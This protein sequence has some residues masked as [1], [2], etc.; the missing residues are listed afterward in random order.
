MS[1]YTTPLQFG[2][3]LG[4]AMALR[5]WFRAYKE[6][7]LADF[8][9]GLLLCLLSLEIQDYTFGFAGINILWDEYNG[10]YRNVRLLLWPTLFFYLQAQTNLQF[11]FKPIY[12]LHYVP[13]LVIFLVHLIVFLQGKY[14]VQEFQEKAMISWW[15]EIPFVLSYAALLFYGWHIRK[16]LLKYRDWVKNQYS[17]TELVSFSWFRNMH[18]AMLA[19]F[20]FQFIMIHVDNYYDLS[21]YQDWW[22]NLGIVA[23]IFYISV[24]GYSQL[25]P[26]LSYEASN[27]QP[28]V[29]KEVD[30]YLIEQLERHIKVNKPYL[31]PVLNLKELAGQLKTNSSELSFAI[32]QHYQKNF[33]DF[34]NELRV[35]EFIRL[36][37]SE[38]GKNYTLLANAV[39][40]GFNSKATFNRA[41][42]K[43]K[44]VSPAEWVRVKSGNDKG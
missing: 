2:Y 7:R 24:E 4:F 38:E 6:G 43:S 33:N 11:K 26:N 34:I 25:Q 37:K 40:S 23:I 41:F 36:V 1:I 28:L 14:A 42:K 3:F 30:S 44:G 12:L 5:F 20:T 19:G 32:N 18:Y 22:W 35:E 39:D 17:N 27:M 15:G 13:W 8:F 9:M 21:F 29:E 31:N 16:I 10:I